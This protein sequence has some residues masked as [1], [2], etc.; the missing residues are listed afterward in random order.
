MVD[1]EALN[2]AADV[3]RALITGKI[4][5]DAFENNWWKLVFCWAYLVKC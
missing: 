3:F 4:S 1:R 5:D 2:R